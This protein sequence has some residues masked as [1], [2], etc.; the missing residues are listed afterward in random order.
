MSKVVNVTYYYDEEFEKWYVT[1]GITEI[2][3]ESEDEAQKKLMEIAW[4]GGQ[5]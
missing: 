3:V 5:I 1:N 2:E 4:N